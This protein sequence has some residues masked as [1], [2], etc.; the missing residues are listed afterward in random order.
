MY[1]NDTTSLYLKSAQ[2]ANEGDDKLYLCFDFTY[3][4]P[5]KG[6]KALY[7][8]E[9]LN[10][11]FGDSVTTVGNSLRDAN[12]SYEDAVSTRGQ[13]SGTKI[14][15]YVSTEAM[16]QA[17]ERVEFDIK[18][19]LITYLKKG[20]NILSVVD[21]VHTDYEGVYM[22][23]TSKSVSDSGDM[24]FRVAW[25]NDTKKEITFGAHYTIE[26][27]NGNEWISVD[28]EKE[29]YWMAIA[30][31][32][33]PNGGTHEITYSAKGFDLSKT[34]RY[35]VISDFYADGEKKYTW[36]EFEVVNNSE[37]YQTERLET[38]KRNYPE[39]F[40]I[41]DTN[42]I[43][44]YVWQM[45][46]DRYKCGLLPIKNT[47]YT[48][49]DPWG[50][51]GISVEDMNLILRHEYA[52]SKVQIVP[53][54]M[55]YSS[56]YYKIDEEYINKVVALFGKSTDSII[57]VY[58]VIE[59]IDTSQGGNKILNVVWHNNTDSEAMF[60]EF[61]TVE[62]KDGENWI[63]ICTADERKFPAISLL[64]M[65]HTTYNKSYS[66]HEFDMSR[67]G[68]Y[69]LRCD[70][71]QILFEIGASDVGLNENAN[72]VYEGVMILSGNNQTIPLRSMLFARSYENEGWL[73]AQGYGRRSFF[74]SNGNFAHPIPAIRRNGNIELELEEN[75]SFVKL[76][77]YD[78]EH[79]EIK[80]SGASFDNIN[81][82]SNGSYYVILGAT[83]LGDF[84]ESENKYEETTYEYIF[85]IIM[86]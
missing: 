77:V 3:D 14:W 4:L 65:P 86:E 44:L 78:L 66:T 40:D 61:F 25:H 35:R 32:I 63:N 39:Y 5:K 23:L 11:G 73:S 47:D 13:G 75:Y 18:L 60:G 82:L 24:T 57:G 69:R 28:T 19:N 58:G 42:G 29:R 33:Q 17:S 76:Q 72:A 71:G 55:P 52:D 1:Q 51:K 67:Q 64:L 45:S 38:L 50:L 2:Y 34:G 10:N 49:S 22:T 7:P 59:S 80:I 79:N 48:L 27:K 20:E 30:Y 70:L 16:K 21:N 54:S 81:D 26:Y 8:Y 83:R 62:F 15:F 37:E 56:Y 46:A 12:K 43:Y 68:T 9:I 85:G 74:D 53:Y 6:G 36:I 84:I 41:D 31:L